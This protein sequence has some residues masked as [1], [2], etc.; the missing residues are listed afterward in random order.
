MSLE[1]DW[2]TRCHC[3]RSSFLLSTCTLPPSLSSPYVTLYVNRA[4]II[5]AR[6][7]LTGQ[8]RL[9]T[10]FYRLLRPDVRVRRWKLRGDIFQVLF[11]AGA[12]RS[13]RVPHSGRPGCNL[14]IA[15]SLDCLKME[16]CVC[17]LKTRLSCP[18]TAIYLASQKDL[19]V[20]ALFYDLVL[21]SLATRNCVVTVST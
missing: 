21:L 11:R 12:V 17:V 4:T 7:C 6:S 1:T 10:P 19:F 14:E 2:Y 18:K 9:F 3:C 13:D 5:R 16:R 8:R 15:G 20:L